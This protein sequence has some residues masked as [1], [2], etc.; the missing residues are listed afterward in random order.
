MFKELCM[1]ARLLWTNNDPNRVV[2]GCLSNTCRGFLQHAWQTTVSGLVFLRQSKVAV[3]RFADCK[4][5]VGIVNMSGGCRMHPPVTAS[6]LTSFMLP[7]VAL[8]NI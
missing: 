6:H 1:G 3:N 8:M 5:R 2:L 4:C 7:P